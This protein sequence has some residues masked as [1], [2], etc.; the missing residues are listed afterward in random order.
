MEVLFSFLNWTSSFSHVDEDTGSKMDIHNLAT[1]ITPN[2]LYPNVK[3]GTVDESFM[4][5]EAVNA[6]ITYNDTMCEVRIPYQLWFMI[7]GLTPF[8]DSGGSAI[9]PQ[10]SY[11]FPG[12][13]RSDNERNFEALWG[14]RPRQF[15]S[16]TRERRR[17]VHHQQFQPKQQH[18]GLGAHRN[19]PFAGRSLADAKFGPSCPRT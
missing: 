19:R 10:R 16:Q 7:M 3:N 2:I 6:L 18:A 12:K 1:V 4:A 8:Q 9:H 15:L 5:I 13:R 11:P 17:N 14:H